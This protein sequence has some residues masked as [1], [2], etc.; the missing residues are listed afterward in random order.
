MNNFMKY[1]FLTAL[2]FGLCTA[3]LGIFN[4]LG[5]Q[6]VQTAA[7]QTRVT[8][9]AADGTPIAHW[10]NARRVTTSGGTTWFN[11]GDT[12]RRRGITGTVL[13]QY[14]VDD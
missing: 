3:V 14:G 12:N 5:E 13:I 1:V 11:D 8:L 4:K 2:V 9:Y 10:S 7:D 6:P